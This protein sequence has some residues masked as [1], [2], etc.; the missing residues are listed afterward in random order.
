MRICFS[1]LS[2]TLPVVTDKLGRKYRW[3]SSVEFT[4]KL[5]ILILP[6]ISSME[7]PLKSAVRLN[8]KSL[9]L[10]LVVRFRSF[11]RKCC[12]TALR[13]KSGVCCE[14]TNFPLISIF[15]LG[16][17][18][19]NRPLNPPR[20]YCPSRLMLWYSYCLY[21]NEA[22]FP[23]MYD[24]GLLFL[25][26][27]PFSSTSKQVFPKVF[28]WFNRIPRFNSLLEIFPEYERKP[29]RVSVCMVTL[30]LIVPAFEVKLPFVVSC[31]K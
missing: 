19:A 30:P 9:F 10:Y 27:N 11:G 6:C 31:C 24:S 15:P 18:R 25:Y 1:L 29:V 4:S 26:L 5:S 12:T 16:S 14:V 7:W 21:S 28:S 17:L 13:L 8:D 2:L 3:S 20:V 22:M 23:F